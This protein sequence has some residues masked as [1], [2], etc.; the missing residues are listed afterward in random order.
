MIDWNQIDSVFLDLDGTLLDLHFDN[1]FWHEHLPRRYG[2]LRGLSLEVARAELLPRYAAIEGTLNWYC[3][4]HWSRELGLDIVGLK[5][6]VEHLIA[7]HPHVVDFLEYLALLGKRRLLV[8][9][10]HR[11]TLGLKMAR[12]RLAGHFD[13]IV[14]AHDLGEAK[15]SPNFW[16]R[17]QAIESFDPER[18]LFID[19]NLSV[20]RTA[21]AFGLRWLIAVLAPDSRKPRRSSDEFSGIGDFSEL[22]KPRPDESGCDLVARLGKPGSI[23]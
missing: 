7:V 12:T 19:D 11:K 14:S 1:H 18:T 20:L 4:D 9:N 21:R 23:S 13:R 2:E 10:A 6:E 3:V 16:T 15:E 8:T 22:I 17:F 5:Q